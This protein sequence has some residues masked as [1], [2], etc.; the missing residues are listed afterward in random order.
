M[1]LIAPLLVVLAQ[2]ASPAPAPS[3]PPS[4][5]AACQSAAF[6]QFDFWLGDWDVTNQQCPAG[7][8]CPT[9][10]N[11]I[12]RILHGCAILEEYETP[13]GYTGKSL[14]FHD[15]ASKKWHQTWIDS[16]G[17]PLFIEGG[18]EGTSM[19]MRD[20]SGAN[21]ITWT[22]LAGGRVR[23]HWEASKDGGKTFATV[24]DGL[25]TPRAKAP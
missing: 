16:G 19:V 8:K 14:N 9:S 7:R 13:A 2:A 24:F 23:Q 1:A 25:Y 10:H 22:P 5:G 18:L 20:T 15:A 4:P 3:T 17:Q 6:R 12:S 21:R 11:R